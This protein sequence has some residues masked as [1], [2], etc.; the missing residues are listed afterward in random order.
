MGE[1]INNNHLRDEKLI[2][3]SL[4][5]RKPELEIVNLGHF[6]RIVVEPPVELP[7]FQPAAATPPV[8]ELS[9]QPP[10][11]TSDTEPYISNK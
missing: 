10:P 5:Q 7:P 1:Y 8:Q 11:E 6:F 3:K 9:E 4:L 2:E